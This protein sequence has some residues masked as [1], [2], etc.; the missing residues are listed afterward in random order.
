MNKAWSFLTC[1]VKKALPIIGD[2]AKHALREVA[3]Q[4]VK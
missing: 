2:V 1:S 4:G 3:K